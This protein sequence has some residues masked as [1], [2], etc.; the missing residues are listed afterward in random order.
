MKR[1]FHHEAETESKTTTVTDQLINE[2]T[3]AIRD[4]H[5]RQ[6]R[7][8]TPASL[9]PDEPYVL[10]EKK[11]QQYL[12]KH[13]NDPL[14][15]KFVDISRK[16]FIDTERFIEF[17]RNAATE[18]LSQIQHETYLQLLPDTMNQYGLYKSNYWMSLIM[19][20]ILKEMGHPPVAVVT[21]RQAIVEWP[22][23]RN[24]LLVDD[25][26]YSG[27]QMA[28]VFHHITN[29]EEELEPTMKKQYF[30]VVAACSRYSERTFHHHAFPALLKRLRVICGH[31]M[32]PL[33]AFFKKRELKHLADFDV[34]PKN[35]FPVFLAH[36]IPDDRS[37]FPGVYE[38]II[39]DRPKHQ[40]PYPNRKFVKL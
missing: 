12:E 24:C 30:I 34:T 5:I 36:K 27:E 6:Q 17:C 26:M 21:P 37:S 25:A 22:K 29:L 11:I 8:P 23:I 3:Q 16:E 9:F 28:L 33:L 39:R 1:K 7:F 20:D 10:D 14:L 4:W 32:R 31:A 2:E 13:G 35:N 38:K 15:K 18:F 19:Y 40:N